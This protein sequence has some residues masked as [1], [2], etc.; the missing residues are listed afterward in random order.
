LPVAAIGLFV[1]T[2]TGALA[3]S[4]KSPVPTGYPVQITAKEQA[5]IDT[6]VSAINS[7]DWEKFKTLMPA[8]VQAC[9][10]QDVPRYKDVMTLQIPDTRQIDIVEKYTDFLSMPLADYGMKLPP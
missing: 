5:F 4:T 7:H 9:L 1:F 8:S 6:Y 2:V 10:T 3:S